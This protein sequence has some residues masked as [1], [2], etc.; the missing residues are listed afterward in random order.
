MTLVVYECYDPVMSCMKFAYG[1][2][3]FFI[4]HVLFFRLLHFIHL[5]KCI[6][7]HIIEPVTEIS[8]CTL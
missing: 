3:N 5:I 4:H 8:L 1:K 6:F 7:D 2:S